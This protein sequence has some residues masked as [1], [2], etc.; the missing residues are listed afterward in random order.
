MRGGQTE[1]EDGGIKKWREISVKEEGFQI[2]ATNKH[3]N[4]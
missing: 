2:G 4:T 1:V 3:L